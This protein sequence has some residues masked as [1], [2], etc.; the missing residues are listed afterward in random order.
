MVHPNTLYLFLGLT[1]RFPSDRGPSSPAEDSKATVGAF[2][3]ARIS[4][5][6]HSLGMLPDVPSVAGAAVCLDAFMLSFAKTRILLV[7]F[8]VKMGQKPY[9]RVFFPEAGVI[10]TQHRGNRDTGKFPQ[11]LFLEFWCA[12]FC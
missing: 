12:C 7:L 3:R 8:E 6:H 5:G 1:P 2:P 11:E 10:P 9:V 4:P